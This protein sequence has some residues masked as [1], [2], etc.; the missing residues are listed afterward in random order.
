VT[1]RDLAEDPQAVAIMG[2]LSD[3]IAGALVD[4]AN[5]MESVDD[6]QT[7]PLRHEELRKRADFWLGWTQDPS[8]GTSGKQQKSF[9]AGPGAFSLPQPDI[10]PHAVG[11]VADDANASAALRWTKHPSATRARTVFRPRGSRGGLDTP[12]RHRY[13]A[14][15]WVEE[16]AHS[17]LYDFKHSRPHETSPYAQSH[18]PMRMKAPR[19]EDE[20]EDESMAFQ[21]APSGLTGRQAADRQILPANTGMMRPNGRIDRG[22]NVINGGNPS[23]ADRDFGLRHLPAAVHTVPELVKQDAAAQGVRNPQRV[24][25]SERM[26]MTDAWGFRFPDRSRIDFSK[27]RFYPA[28]DGSD[29]LLYENAAKYAPDL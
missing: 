6:R 28:R 4:A 11:Q 13:L 7:N 25:R 20:L 12:Q 26:P 5:R 15:D 17:I 21:A 2:D 3:G 23:V 19:E 10:V 8:I 24:T 18:R 1:M 14:D 22:S 29:Q 9:G 16:A 27:P